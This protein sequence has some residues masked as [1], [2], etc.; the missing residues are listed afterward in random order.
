[1][2][3][4]FI[5]VDGIGI[6]PEGDHNPL[7][8][9]A[10]ELPALQILAGG[11]LVTG[12]KSIITDTN[13]FKPVDANLG[14]EGLPQSGTGQTALFTGVNASEFLG[15]HFGPFPHSKIKPFLRDSGLFKQASENGLSAWF[16][17]AY[18][19][20][21]FQR[22]EKTGRWS[23][24]TY[25]VKE[26]GGRLNGLE[27]LEAERAITAEIFGD[28]WR[29]KLGIKLP[30]LT[31]E[32]AARRILSQVD[33][34]DIVMYEYYLTDKAGHDQT[35]EF[36]RETLVRLD[37]LLLP[38]VENLNG[39][40]LVLCSDH[41]NIE[42]LSTKTHTRNPVPLFAYGPQAKLFSEAES[43]LDVSVNIIEAAKQG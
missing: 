29:E 23:S 21:F 16:M 12:T 27:D 24:S 15:R 26:N 42:D 34:H 32:D 4:I 2:S 3:V 9:F 18:P 14:V 11:N 28:Y 7:H 33:E 35:N 41:G 1:M 39:K 20:I 25:M 22:L 38:L 6:G 13:V 30:D 40:T 36:A 43:I 19:P 8:T 37:A 17:N 5:F 31:G 10:G